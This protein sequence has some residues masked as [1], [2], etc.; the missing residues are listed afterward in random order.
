[1]PHLSLLIPIVAIVFGCGIAIIAIITEYYEKKRYHESLVKALETGNDPEKVK[2]LFKLP[3]KKEPYT[4]RYLHKGI[5][6]IAVGI[7]AGL[8]GLFINTRVIT[9]IGVFLCILGLAF[10]L[11][12]YLIKKNRPE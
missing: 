8:F 5:T 1:M 12:H 4:I 7:G 11:I 10:L 3:E 2:E 6:T 9:G